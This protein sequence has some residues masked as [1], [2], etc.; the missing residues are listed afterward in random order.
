MTA[1]W[2]GRSGRRCRRRLNRQRV[3]PFG[4]VVLKPMTAWKVN[5]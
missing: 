2:P 4:S 3:V 5:W 1:A